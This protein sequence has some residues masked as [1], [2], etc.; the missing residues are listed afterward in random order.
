MR[1]EF[2]ALISLCYAGRRLAF[3]LLAVL[4]ASGCGKTPD[5]AI[6]SVSDPP[7]VRLIQPRVRT[8]TRVVGQPSFVEAYERTSIYPK[9]TGYIEKWYVDIGDKVR[10][11]DVLATLF[12]PELREDWE[13]KKATVK[14]DEERVRLALKMVEVAQADVQAAEARL[15]EAKAILGQYQAQVDRWDTEVKRLR[16]EAEKG[17]VAPQILLES[18]DQLKRSN[19]AREAAKATIEK[20]KAELLSKNA[21]FAEANVDV[22][23]SRARVTVAKSDAKRLEAWVGYLTLTAPYD[24]VI[25]ARNANT[26]DFVLP[27]TGDPTADPRAPHLSPSGKAAPIYVIDRT[28]IVRIFVD[29]PEADANYVHGEKDGYKGDHPIGTKATVL[30]R[31]YRDELIPATVTRTAWALNVKSR[32][33]RAEVDLHNP[34]SQILPGMYAYGKV[35]VERPNVRA[36]PLSALAYSGDDTF[37]WRYENGRAVRTKVQTGVTDGEWIE[38]TNR[39]RPPKASSTPKDQ[40]PWTPIDGSEQVILGDLSILAEGSP[41][42]VGSENEEAEVAKATPDRRATNTD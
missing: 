5:A 21:S 41:V 34:K 42:K 4:A 18:E 8:I 1:K 6:K 19:A 12:V 11:G 16:R 20:A 36:L 3:S 17:V 40:G 22:D 15:V 31:A 26:F 30:V 14:L 10:K 23:V 37:Y 39:Q 2:F 28:D 35:I 24:G 29:I 38:V 13:T 33:L 32:T 9:V 27:S 7:V 25:V